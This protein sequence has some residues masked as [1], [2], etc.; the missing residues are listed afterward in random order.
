MAGLFISGNLAADLQKTTSLSNL[1]HFTFHPPGQEMTTGKQRRLLR[2][3]AVTDAVI[4]DCS[5]LS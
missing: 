3:N 2:Q 1:A 5:I 4:I